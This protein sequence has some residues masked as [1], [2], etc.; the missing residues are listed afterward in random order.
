[1]SKQGDSVM[2]IWSVDRDGKI[3]PTHVASMSAIRPVINVYKR[4]IDN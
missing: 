1:M 2:G 3:T 4:A